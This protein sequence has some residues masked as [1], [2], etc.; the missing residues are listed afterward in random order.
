L[1]G[2]S[3]DTVRGFVLT[4]LD[5]ALR[6]HGRAGPE[7][8]DDFDILAE[9]VVDSFALVELI[10]SIES[11][12][13][14]VLD[15]EDVDADDLTVL[16]PF[17]RYVAERIG[18]QD[19]APSLSGPEPATSGSQHHSAP[20]ATVDMPELQFV[21]NSSRGRMIVGRAAIQSYRLG[22]RARDKLFSL[23]IRGSFHAFGTKT[24]IQLPVRL[25]GEKHIAIGNGSF[26]GAGSWLQVIGTPERDVAIEIGDGASFAGYC[27]L[28]ATQS[29]RIGKSVSFA[30]NV[31]V[32]DHAHAYEDSD[33]PI[34]EQGLTQIAPISIGEGAWLG[35]NVVVLPGT[36]IGPGAVIGANSVVATDV[37]AR[38]LAIGAPARVIRRFGTT[39]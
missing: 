38:S 25:S 21:E 9:G 5:G 4:H 17:C 7:I 35:E 34:L 30:R 37:P 16:G 29:I 32:A 20:G 26:V 12:F 24:V 28:S 1:T 31:Y 27:I 22:V 23:L 14:I 11:H 8:T 15:F 19:G 36:T 33:L 39:Q 10:E 6:E 13:G 3:T 18:D 2:N